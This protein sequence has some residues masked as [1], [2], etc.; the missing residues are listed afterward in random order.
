MMSSVAVVSETEYWQI[1]GTTVKT[2]LFSV[3][4]NQDWRHNGITM[5]TEN[6]SAAEISNRPTMEDFHLVFDVVFV[7]A[8][9]YVNLCAD[10][11]AAQYQLVRSLACFRVCYVYLSLLAFLQLSLCVCDSA[12]S[13]FVSTRAP[14]FH[15]FSLI[16]SNPCQLRSQ[17]GCAPL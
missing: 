17:R 4:A 10:M 12:T 2:L 7:D 1:L 15:V 3:A 5:A 6:W 9:G 14:S 8:S 11:S 16:G 13:N